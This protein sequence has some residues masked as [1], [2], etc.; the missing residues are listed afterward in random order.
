MSGLL[1]AAIV[2]LATSLGVL[3]VRRNRVA[4]VTKRVAPHVSHI[5]TKTAVEVAPPRRGRLPLRVVGATLDLVRLRE[6]FARE[7]A[8]AGSTRAPEELALL[9]VGLG[10][11]LGALG[12]LSSLSTLLYCVFAILGALTPHAVLQARNRRRAKAFDEQLPDLLDLLVGSLS[13]GHSFAQSLRAVAE[14]AVEPAATEFRQ[15]LA[16]IRLGQSTRGALSSVA[17]RMRSR[18]LPFVLTAVAIQEQV[19]GSLAPLLK[20]VADS[21]RQ[22]QQFRRKVKSLTSMG[23]AS[24]ISLV[25]LPFAAAALISVVQPAYLRPLWQTSTGRELALGA[26]VLMG[27]GVVFLRRIVSVGS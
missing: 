2:G 6:P 27:V 19:G 5:A 4:W 12:R 11:A 14:G 3:V 15:A 1:L 10:V 21:V 22:R 18:D 7:L 17:E 8:G 16:E 23:R 20:S 25:A 24:A 9:C 13:I 26:F